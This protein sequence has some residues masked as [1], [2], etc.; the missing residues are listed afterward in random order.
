M[1]YR[2]FFEYYLDLAESEK[3]SDIHF[4]PSKKVVVRV[5]GSLKPIGDRILSSKD[6]EEMAKIV[7]NEKQKEMLR[8]NMDAD[9]SFS[10]DGKKRFRCNAYYDMYGLS[11]AIRRYFDNLKGFKE[12]GIP[13]ILKTY[14]LKKSGFI[15]IT[16]P[17]GSGKTTTL[18]TVIDFMNKNRSGH[19]ITIE[20]PIEVVF[21]SNKCLI[22][23][24]EIS[25]DTPSFPIA[26]KAVL[27]QDP[28]VIV[29]GEMRDLES[30][31]T[32]LTA[33]E[34]GH[35]VLAT[36]HTSGA[37]NAIDRI[38]DSFPADQQN[39]VRMQL[40]TVLSCVISQQL[41]PSVDER[42]VLATEVM[43]GTGAVRSLIR[44]NKIQLIKNAMYTS[45]PQGM[46][47]F[48]QNFE[49]LFSQGYISSADYKLYFS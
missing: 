6:I 19:I 31:A 3:A 39:Q 38:V 28:D 37:V 1:N 49:K 32:A 47:T 18:A 35:L 21:K 27:R 42:R 48:E 14:S 7:M 29:I 24:R 15:L 44:Q 20:D 41:I 33:A 34:T 25:S 12:L 26:L 23:Q 10:L 16:G 13:E 5:G 43:V 11:M 2:E 17:T 30:M 45:G 46:Y 8:V 22:T 4:K 9:F 36:M 40:S